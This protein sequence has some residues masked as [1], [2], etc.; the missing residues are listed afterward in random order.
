MMKSIND[1]GVENRTDSFVN[2]KPFS[3]LILI[4]IATVPVMPL[5]IELIVNWLHGHMVF[6]SDQEEAVSTCLR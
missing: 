5:F 3:M 1:F 6:K 4:L 2:G